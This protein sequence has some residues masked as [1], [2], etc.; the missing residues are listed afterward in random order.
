MSSISSID[1]VK[2]LSDTVISISQN[3]AQSATS[4][5]VI[6]VDCSL[7]GTSEICLRCIQ[8]FRNLQISRNEEIDE[9]FIRDTCKS[10]CICEV[11][12]VFENAQV[13]CNFD[14]LQTSITA[15]D[16]SAAFDDNLYTEASKKGVP[17]PGMGSS[18]EA[19]NSALSEVLNTLQSDTVQTSLQSIAT[20]QN[21]ELIGPGSVTSVDM[22][23]MVSMVSTILLSNTQASESINKLSTILRNEVFQVTEAGFAQIILR[24]VQIII[25]IVLLVL[26]G[27][28]FQLFLQLYTLQTTL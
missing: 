7:P 8:A 3:I 10:S 22:N 21:I 9:D 4:A 26:S 24:F 1:I 6:R 11:S 25:I 12:D 20:V 2:V 18:Q 14:A 28:I 15:E 27:F 16:F 17:L 13:S 19:R 5:Q 23:T